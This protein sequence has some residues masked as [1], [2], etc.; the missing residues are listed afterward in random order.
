MTEQLSEF[1]EGVG[2]KPKDFAQYMQDNFPRVQAKTW[3]MHMDKLGWE[4]KSKR[5]KLSDNKRVFNPMWVWSRKEAKHVTK[6]Q[7][8]KSRVYGEGPAQW[9]EV[10]AVEDK[11]D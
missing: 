3:K 8:W 10:N 7:K 6:L 1:G 2:I 5:P 11:M 9:I 4:H